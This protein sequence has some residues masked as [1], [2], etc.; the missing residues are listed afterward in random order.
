M[1]ISRRTVLHRVNG[2]VRACDSLSPVKEV[3]THGFVNFGTRWVEVVESNTLVLSLGNVHQ[4]P[5][6][7][8]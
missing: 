7:R 5:L 3:V 1:S 2:I 4:Y 8:S 6:D